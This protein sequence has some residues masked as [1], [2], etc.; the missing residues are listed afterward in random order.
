METSRIHKNNL[1]VIW[2]GIVVMCLMTAFTYHSDMG[3]VIGG[4][5]TM[6]I[7]G[8]VG[9]VLYVS[10]ANDLIKAMG[11]L[12][13]PSIATF[14]YSFVV[15]GSAVSFLA[16][17]LFAA[18]CAVYFE[19]TYIKWYTIV[20]AVASVISIIADP[21]IIDGIY[22]TTAGAIV[23]AALLVF[24]EVAL[25]MAVRR[26]RYFIEQ[27][28][29]SLGLVQ[30]NEKTANGIAKNL[31]SAISDCKEGMNHL[32]EQANSVSESASQM[33][34]VVESTTNATIAF[35][36]KINNANEQV[37]RNFEMARNLED[38]FKQVRTSVDDGDTE[39]KNFQEDL[40][41]MVSVVG[42][43][44]EATDGLLA[45]MSKI[46]SILEEIN[47]I[48]SQT[49]LL[50]LNASIE[51]ARAGE[52]GRGFAVVA[53]E[54]RL[55]AEQ[56]SQAA[57]NIKGILDGLTA[58][59]GDV[60]N[61]INAGAKAAQEGV[62]KMVG[63][64]E[65]FDGIRHST[66][67]A[68]DMVNQEYEVIENIRHVFGEIQQEIETLVATNE[69]N[70]AMIQSIAENIMAQHDSVGDVKEEIVGIAGLSNDLKEQ[71]GMD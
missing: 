62:E 29:E 53:D 46:T 58:T 20:M 47:A 16:N 39:A 7:A 2:V 48:A 10:S 56:S 19:D 66:T 64:L 30:E 26:G 57:D 12:L 65:V 15:G 25:I 69:E 4:C 51:A 52:H 67:E 70:S 6:I 21:H 43:A 36:E 3:M 1:T 54:I 44:R 27:A 9:I 35:S 5:L 71:F 18:M 49:N 40:G 22:A 24:V 8:I 33:G 55:L 50:S 38:S 23:K 34:K 13:V 42:S 11:I 31:N 59:T 63:L 28:E 41:E 60:S 17:Y 14:V 61:K 68:Q 45:E 37:D 32:V